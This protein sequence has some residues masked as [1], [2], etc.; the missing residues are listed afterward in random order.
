MLKQIPI[1]VGICFNIYHLSFNMRI[2]IPD[3][4]QN[5]IKKLDAFQLLKGHEVTIVHEYLSNPKDLA[6]KLN[7]PEVLVLTRSRTRVDE[8]LL[9]L[10]PNLKLVS[11]TGKN[12]GHIDIEACTKYGVK[13]VEGQGDPVAPAELTWNLIMNGLRQI[14]QAME[15]MKAGHWQINLGRRVFGKRIGIWGYGK[16]GK[17]IA[18]YA[19]VFGAEVMV[20]GSEG[21][22]NLAKADGFLA[23]ENQQE[24]FST[25]D[26]VTLHLRLEAATKEIVKLSDLLNMKLDA[27]LVNTSRAELIEKGALLTALQ[28]GKPGFAAVDVYD[29]E[30][31]FDT[32][33]PFLQMSN[34]IC[35]PHL[36]YVERAGYELYFSIAFKN[37][38]T[39]IE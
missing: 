13:V 27:L 20:W 24:F 15:G 1:A 28:Q 18:Q 25:C 3:D 31:I 21:S 34:V 4:Y 5:V 23:A 7:D 30:P 29:E 12:A 10:L 6:A 22:R 9:Q 35:T 36:G 17:R 19:K 37:V 39:N 33:H 32:H 38:I 16:I 8:A 2:A 26:V 11:Q 14:P